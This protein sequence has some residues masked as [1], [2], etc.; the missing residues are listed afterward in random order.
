M[1][2]NIVRYDIHN[3]SY[4]HFFIQYITAA[5]NTAKFLLIESRIVS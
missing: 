5:E 2:I 1:F 4:V 3:I